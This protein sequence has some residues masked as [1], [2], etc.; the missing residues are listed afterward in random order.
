MPRI[1]SKRDGLTVPQAAERVGV[2]TNTIYNWIK[3]GKL[4]V[5]RFGKA[6]RIHPDDLESVIERPAESE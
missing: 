1:E 2:H 3:S 6:T 5:T 4:A